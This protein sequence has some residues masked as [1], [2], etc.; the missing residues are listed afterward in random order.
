MISLLDIIEDFIQDLLCALSLATNHPDIDSSIEKITDYIKTGRSDGCKLFPE[1]MKVS[2]EVF[3][4]NLGGENTNVIECINSTTNELIDEEALNTVS[5]ELTKLP[6]VIA[7]LGK[8]GS[9]VKSQENRTQDATV[10]SQCVNGFISAAHCRQCIKRIPPLCMGTCNA[11]LRGCYSP[12]YT[13]FNGQ[14]AELWTEVGRV[15][16]IASSAVTNIISNAKK[17]VDYSALVSSGPTPADT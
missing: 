2:I 7:A 10:N 4:H 3:S 5:E 16:K 14:F 11:L 13:V 6:S 9:F 1:L 17:V 8:I 12:Y 15:V